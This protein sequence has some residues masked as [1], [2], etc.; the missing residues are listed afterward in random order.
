MFEVV[1]I[2]DLTVLPAK[3]LHALFQ[4]GTFI[5]EYGLWY[6]GPSHRG[7][8][9]FADRF[10]GRFLHW[11]QI[12]QRQVGMLQWSPVGEPDRQPD[13][14]NDQA[15]VRPQLDR[16]VHHPQP[17][18]GCRQ[19]PSQF[20]QSDSQHPQAAGISTGTAVFQTQAGGQ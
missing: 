13:P 1:P 2:E 18:G 19:R 20:E 7:L 9:L 17:V 12:Q 6:A 3:Q 15:F 14:H 5:A 16:V 11:R 8:Q 10:A 4:L